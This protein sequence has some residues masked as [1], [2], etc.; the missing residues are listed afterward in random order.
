MTHKFPK[1]RT[2][3]WYEDE[4]GDFVKEATYYH[5]SVVEELRERLGITDDE[6]DTE[7]NSTDTP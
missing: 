3:S 6:P 2:V 7:V 1:T 4:S 5:S